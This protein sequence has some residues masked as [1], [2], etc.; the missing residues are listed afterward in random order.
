MLSFTY[1]T[2]SA[3]IKSLFACNW[4]FASS[5]SWLAPTGVVNVIAS[6]AVSV[7]TTPFSNISITSFHDANAL[8]SPVSL[9]PF[10]IVSLRANLNDSSVC[11]PCAA[12][13]VAAVA[14]E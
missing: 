5:R 4:S 11:K 8:A 1:A 3:A 12:L 14:L 6:A 2:I 13:L 7:L 10:S 9:N